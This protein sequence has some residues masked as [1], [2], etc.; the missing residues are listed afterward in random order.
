MG[1]SLSVAYLD[2]VRS[3]FSLVLLRFD[4]GKEAQV[5]IAIQGRS[6]RREEYVL[7]NGIQSRH[8]KLKDNE[9]LDECFFCIANT[10]PG[11][12]VEP[13]AASDKVSI[14]CGAVTD[15]RNGGVKAADCTKLCSRNLHW[16]DSVLHNVGHTA[17]WT[18]ALS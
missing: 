7:K 6:D 12:V 1:S 2:V 8:E 10:Q 11:H 14:Y 15:T 13:P 5:E 17:L 3:S 16:N 4:S 9:C 18:Y